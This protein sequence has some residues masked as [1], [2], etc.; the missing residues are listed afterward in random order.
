MKHIKKLGA[1]I[2]GLSAAVVP[3]AAL[4]VMAPS[5]PISTLSGFQSFICN[6]VVGWLFTF[7]IILTVVFV[8][9]AAFKYLTAAG[10]PEKVKSAGNTL[11]YAAVAVVIALFAR[12][13]PLIIESLF[14]TSGGVVC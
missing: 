12:G 11:V 6:I 1:V 10:D 2:S 14:T 13:F 5:A 3:F 7:L 4:A 9:I 8:L